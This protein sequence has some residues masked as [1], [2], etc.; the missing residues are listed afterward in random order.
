MSYQFYFLMFIFLEKYFLS[1]FFSN[2]KQ[3]I[4]ISLL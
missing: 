4:I 3:I 1:S 2:S